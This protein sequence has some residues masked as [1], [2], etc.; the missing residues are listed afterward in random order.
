MAHARPLWRETSLVYRPTVGRPHSVS[1]AE[2]ASIERISGLK[3]SVYFS[4]RSRD[5]RELIHPDE[6]YSRRDMEA[7]AGYLHVPLKW[8]FTT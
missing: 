7:L 1:R 5:G 6:T 2:V 3:G 8:D 4:F